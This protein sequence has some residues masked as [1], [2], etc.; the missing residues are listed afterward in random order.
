MSR[1]LKTVHDDAF[2][3]FMKHMPAPGSEIVA[4]VLKAHLLVEEQVWGIVAT[5]LNLSESLRKAFSNKFDFSELLLIAQAAVPQ[6]DIEIYDAGWVWA[7]V[8]KING[9]RNRIAHDLEPAGTD[10]KFKDIADFVLHDHERGKSVQID[11]FLVTF[12]VCAVLSDLRN[13]VDASDLVGEL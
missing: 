2:G 11:F 1:T 5:R 6:E 3:R 12:N 10:D 13:P 8:E 4:A 9:L 7:A